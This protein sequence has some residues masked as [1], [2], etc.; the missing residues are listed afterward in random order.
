MEITPSDS[1][2]TNGG[3]ER[4]PSLRMTYDVSRGK[5]HFFPGDPVRHGCG[6]V[7]TGRNLRVQEG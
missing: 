3:E 7:T 2:K 1:G 5:S 4:T 6:A